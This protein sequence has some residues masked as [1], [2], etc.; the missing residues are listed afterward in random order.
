MNGIEIRNGK[1]YTYRPLIGAEMEEPVSDFLR[2]RL[3][4]LQGMMTTL[5]QIAG[6]SFWARLRA[7]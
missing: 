6:E 2:Y 4:E 5:E 3:E 1:V 7:V